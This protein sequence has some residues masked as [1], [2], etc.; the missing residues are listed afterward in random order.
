[1]LFLYEKPQ[2]GGEAHPGKLE[3]RS[4]SVPGS[5]AADIISSDLE[6]EGSVKNSDTKDVYSTDQYVQIPKC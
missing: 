4:S 6:V 2:K 3:M 1:M 5:A